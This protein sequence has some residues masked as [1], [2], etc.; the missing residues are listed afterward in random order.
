MKLRLL[1]RK[2]G[3]NPPA[4]SPEAYIIHELHPVVK[5]AVS[6]INE[7]VTYSWAGYTQ[8][9]EDD[10]PSL[11]ASLQFA[12][13]EDARMRIVARGLKAS[14]DFVRVEA[15]VSYT[16]DGEVFAITNIY[17]DTG[18]IYSPGATLTTA[19]AGLVENDDTIEIYVTGEADTSIR[20][21]GYTQ[22]QTASVP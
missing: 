12:T 7:L 21:T 4:E 9:T 13:G 6:K 19:T 5:F 15:E 2:I 16:W 20:W 3:A 18:P 22:V 8:V 1:N 17:L 14:G 11:L 10:T